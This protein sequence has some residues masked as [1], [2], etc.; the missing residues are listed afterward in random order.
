[1][2]SGKNRKWIFLHLLFTVS[3]HHRITYHYRILIVY[4]Y[5][6]Y[7]V[8]LNYSLAHYGKWKKW[9]QIPVII[10]EYIYLEKD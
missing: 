1:M 10:Y 2:N 9:N 8:F 5:D 3:Y 4:F 7:I 6:K